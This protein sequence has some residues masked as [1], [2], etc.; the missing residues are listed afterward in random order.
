MIKV[1]GADVEYMKFSAGEPHVKVTNIETRCI[2]FW[3]FESISEFF[4][5]AM[6]CDVLKRDKSNVVL[7]TNYLPFARQDRATTDDQPFSLKV[8]CHMLKTLQIDTL[9]VSDLHSDVF[10]ELMNNSSFT[11]N[12]FS[13]LVCFKKII[14]N[15]NEINYDL[16][17]SPD[18]GAIRKSYQIANY[19]GLPLVSALKNRDSSTGLLSEP[20]I[21]FKD[22]KPNK[23]LIP[24][25]I[26]DG[27]GT[28]IQLA[29]LIKSKLPSTTIDLYITHGIFSK[30]VEIFKGKFENI[31]CYNI[32]NKSITKYDLLNLNK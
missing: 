14:H 9:G 3:D 28:F 19:L 30:G 13:Q 22:F 11:I 2:I 18:K 26:C 23:I 7:L 8:F 17:V 15:E 12:H 6:I 5:V 16:I 32:M 4:D 27:G 10:F 29:D 21:D 20:S 24:D 1:H 31:Y 25:D